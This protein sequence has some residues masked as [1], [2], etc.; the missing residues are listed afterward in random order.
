LAAACRVTVEEDA[1]SVSPLDTLA[2]AV[3]DAIRAMI[4]ADPEPTDTFTVFLPVAEGVAEYT[5][6]LSWKAW[7][8]AL[9][10]LNVTVTV[11]QTTSEQP[12]W[13]AEMRLP[14]GVTVST[15]TDLNLFTPRSSHRS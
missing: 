3:L 4:D 14:A 13:V 5:V 8:A 10:V 9:A 15:L 7:Q 2:A 1:L 11:A 12:R 6:P